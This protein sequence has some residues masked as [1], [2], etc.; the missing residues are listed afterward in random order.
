MAPAAASSSVVKL[1]VT[2]SESDLADCS[3]GD[4]LRSDSDSENIEAGS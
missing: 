3:H 4:S 1:T 2:D